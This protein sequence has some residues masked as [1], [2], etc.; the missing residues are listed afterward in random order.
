M[1]ADVLATWGLII[2]SVLGMILDHHTIRLLAKAIAKLTKGKVVLN[3]TRRDSD[4]RRMGM[5][6]DGHNPFRDIRDEARR[7]E[8]LAERAEHNREDRRDSI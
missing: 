3:A 4:V 6:A 8:R 5:D 1:Q 7:L 2:V